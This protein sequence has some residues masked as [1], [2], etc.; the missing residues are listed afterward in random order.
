M[1]DYKKLKALTPH[2]G[3][4]ASLYTYK[5]FEGLINLRPFMSIKRFRPAK[6]IKRYEWPVYDWFTEKDVW[7][8]SAIKQVL[9]YSAVY[10]NDATRANQKINGF[11]EG[12]ERVF[13]LPVDCHIY[14]SNNSNKSKGFGKHKDVNHNVIV[15]CE[16]KIN[17]KIY[18]GNKIM[19]KNLSKGDY[20]FVPAGVY[21]KVES[22]S[23]KRLSCSFPILTTHDNNVFDER[24]W[25]SI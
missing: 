3:Q 8:V 25:L 19:N 10:I 23:K 20:A 4:T 17:F 16:G 13:E 15:V 18:N 9:K 14:F 6:D 21:H 11:S 24:E 5:E 7:P 2:F 12:L 1:L 22:L